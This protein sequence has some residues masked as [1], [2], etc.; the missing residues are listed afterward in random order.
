[1]L[2]AIVQEKLLACCAFTCADWGA[3]TA[4]MEKRVW[5]ACGGVVVEAGVTEPP[6]AVVDQARKPHGS[7]ALVLFLQVATTVALSGAVKSALWPAAKA[8]VQLVG[9]LGG[10]FCCTV[11]VNGKEAKQFLTEPEQSATLLL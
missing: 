11:T 5:E 9:G 4:F 1:M 2:S 10:V 3:R 7:T 6:F 8:S